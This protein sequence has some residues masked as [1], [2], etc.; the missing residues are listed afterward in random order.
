MP[1]QH[2]S[3]GPF[4]LNRGSGALLR[5]GVRI[6]VGHRGICVL[7]ALLDRR[8]EVVS[9]ATLMDAV[10]PGMAIEE[11][12]LSVQVAS[13]RKALGT[14]PSGEEWIA[15]VPR[16]GYRFVGEVRI[17][18]GERERSPAFDGAAAS[19]R[20]P[21]IAVLPFA[22][23][24]EDPEQEYFCDGLADDIITGL[25]WLRWLLVIARNS[26]FTYRGKSIDVR[27]VGRELEAGYVL[28]G[29][30]RRSG[31]RMRVAAQLIDA[32]T[33]LQVWAERYDSEVADLFALQ[34]QI[35]Q[36][37]VASIEPHLYAAEGFR[38]E[39]RP[40]ESLDAWGFVMRAMPYIWTWK[41]T[42]N[43]KA[44]AYLKRATEIDPGYARAN[45]L[46]A[47]S[48]AA[49]L[50]TGWAP[51]DESLDLALA[52]ARLGVEQD[53]ADPWAHLALGFGYSMRRQS[54]PAVEELT[55]SIELNPNFAFGHA[56]LGMTQGYAGE[57]DKGLRHL[58]LAMRLSPRD[59]QQARYLSSTGLCHLMA[60]RFGE[61]VEFER[62]AVQLRPH[63]LAAWRTLAASAAL[64]G[65][66]AGAGVALAE[67]RRLQSDL[68][69]DWIE[70][71]IPI[72]QEEDRSLYV[73]GLRS[74]GLT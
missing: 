49:R 74:A 59:P 60:R 35:T 61:A 56:M 22:N 3:F 50:H 45:S 16:S 24:S 29:S 63:F 53:G 1:E 44:I 19:N 12:N 43:E 11:S 7:Q 41:A 23:L 10:W 20:E 39:R 58:A 69:I 14:S 52:F 64:A 21:S 47:W 26:S 13:L 54:R 57:A 67:A 25:S 4:T 55:A 51:L 48:Y 34:D 62:R 18:G 2:F 66:L 33:G 73:E 38:S 27:Q 15:T 70:K 32:S 6:A 71:Y 5:D 36:S 8:G 37:V 65:D 31:Q 40:P 46:I 28:E 17:L 68:S 30:V 9:R 72:V 42:D